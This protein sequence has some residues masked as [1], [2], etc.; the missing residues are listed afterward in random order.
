MQIPN[1]ATLATNQYYPPSP[2]TPTEQRSKSDPDLP[3]RIST[4]EINAN[5]TA[6]NAPES[7]RS[8]SLPM[9]IYPTNPKPV[10]EFLRRHGLPFSERDVADTIKRH[11]L[12]TD[13]IV[14]AAVAAAMDEGQVT[15][16]NDNDNPANRFNNPSAQIVNMYKE[17][18]LHSG[19]HR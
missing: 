12:L 9:D 10:R 4:S 18:F 13:P 15:D 3:D 2:V 17:T 11:K 1:G 6:A 5:D 7:V 8:S 16:C 19:T 14:I